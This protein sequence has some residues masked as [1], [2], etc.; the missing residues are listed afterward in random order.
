M[1]A[2]RHDFTIEQGTTWRRTIEYKDSVGAPIV[3]TGWTARMQVRSRHGSAATL[4]SLTSTP[5]AGISIA[6]NVL[7][8]VATA[9][10]TAVLPVGRSVYDLELVSP[11]GEVTRLIEGSILVDPEVTR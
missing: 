9:A 3:L 10:Q 5:A 1:T 4:L 2:A 11:A 8:V 7:T 6:S